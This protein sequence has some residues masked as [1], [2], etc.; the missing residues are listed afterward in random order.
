MLLTKLQLTVL[1][2]L[3]QGAIAAGSGLLIQSSSLNDEPESPSAGPQP[4]SANPD[5]GPAR[6]TVTG[7]ALDPE[8]K[9]VPNA[10]IVIHARNMAR[11]PSPDWLRRSLIP[12]GETR[13]DGSGRFRLDAP[14]TSSSHYDADL[15]ALALAPG[16]GAGWAELDV[17]DDSPAADISLRSEQI[18]L[19]RLLDLQGAP[20]AGVTVSVR[21]ISRILPVNPATG[22]TPVEGV[23]YYRTGINDSPGWPRPATTNSEGRFNLRGVGREV[24]VALTVHHPQFAL[25][26]IEVVT[27]G[28]AESKSITAT[29]VP[30]QILTGR[31][32]YADTGK[33]VAHA[34]LGIMSSQGRIGI[35][36]SFETDALGRFRVNPPPGGG[37][38]V[39][40]YSPQCQ[41]YL[42]ATKRLEWPKGA[43][44]QT[45]DLAL[46][47]GVLVR[48]KVTETDS[49]KPIPGATVEYTSR[50]ELQ[51]RRVGG[52][53]VNTASDGSFQLG[54][55]PGPG[56]L[57]VK[58][59]PRP[60][61]YR[62]QE[63]GGIISHG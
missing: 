37:F 5:P 13:A 23:L 28:T 62:G 46:P 52:I 15:G 59:D 2:L 21:S 3:F 35:L 33:G 40:A 10:V 19:G 8:G 11:A 54:A 27:D 55:E 1:T 57:F 58:R 22:R 31:V 61:R 47:R 56:Y 7:R 50:S 30:A 6:M 4:K 53:P 51:N 60:G 43:I 25:Q 36:S 38:S 44:E 17:D 29:V 14:R 42:I 41:P 18:V 63:A 20:A 32:T 34:P 9:P 26:T 48:G 24:R 39:T 49:G 12:L 16:Y 45:L